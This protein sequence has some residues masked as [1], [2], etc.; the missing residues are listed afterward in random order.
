MIVISLVSNEAIFAAMHF[1]ED[2]IGNKYQ[3]KMW[4]IWIVIHLKIVYN[5]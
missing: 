1:V 4:R 5:I 2:A 3:S